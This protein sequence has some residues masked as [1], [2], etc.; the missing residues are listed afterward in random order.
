LAN[1]NKVGQEAKQIRKQEQGPNSDDEEGGASP[2]GLTDV[3][4]ST[5]RSIEMV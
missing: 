5:L 3:M 2:V 1:R 4:K